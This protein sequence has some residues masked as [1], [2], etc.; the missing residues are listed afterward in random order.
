VRNVAI[1]IVREK[2]DS[3]LADKAKP[4][5][6]F[7]AGLV[8]LAEDM[9]ETMAHYNGI[10]LAAPQIGIPK[11]ILVIDTQVEGQRLAMVNPVILEAD[12]SEID[13]EGCLSIPGIYGEVDRSRQLKVRFQD[14]SGETHEIAAEGLFARAIQHEFDHLCGRLFD[15]LVLR[16]V[17]LEELEQDDD[18][19]EV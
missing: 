9:F 8:A 2:G 3:V 14:L 4:V 15:E 11:Q 7:D 18:C 12:G 5:R 19:E 6:R 10:G 13:I 16:F 1:R 17:P